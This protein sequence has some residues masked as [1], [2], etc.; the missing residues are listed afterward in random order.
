MNTGMKGFY[1][2]VIAQEAALA[3]RIV[4]T[5][6]LRH[7]DY[8]N[9]VLLLACGHRVTRLAGP[10]ARFGM[11]GCPQCRAMAQASWGMQ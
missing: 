3:V 7:R 4:T 1:R 2:K 11:V 8:K 10:L 9:H 6:R 5:G